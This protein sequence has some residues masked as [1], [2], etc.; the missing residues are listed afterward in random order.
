[1]PWCTPRLD[2]IRRARIRKVFT[3]ADKVFALNP[4]LLHFLPG[5]EFL[6]YASVNP[7]EWM[8]EGACSG[9][10][11]APGPFRVLHMPTERSIKGTKYVEQ[12]C[13]TLRA[14]GWPVDLILA[15]DVPH[16]QVK[17][18]IAQADLVVDQ[19]LVGW[20]GAFAVEAM[21]MRKPVLC[22]LREED[23]KRFVTFRERIPIVRTT[24][25]TLVDDLRALLRAP[26]SW[27]EIGS[28]GRRF[29]ED[30]HDPLKIARQTIAAYQRACAR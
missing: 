6:P 16:N 9:D 21:A 26:A 27:E 5:A 19:L 1:V 3:Y 29:V 12:A 7:V 28:A 11:R 23:L 8:P 30:C 18:L 20:Y 4:D 25:A 13:A 2:A 10:P 15:E 22:Y 14:E 17:A 24:T